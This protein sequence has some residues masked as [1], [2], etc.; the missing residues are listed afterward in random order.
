MAQSQIRG[1]GNCQ[2]NRRVG[3]REPW[4]VMPMEP[5]CMEPR[6]AAFSSRRVHD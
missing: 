5:Q 4:E 1:R 6:A 3:I 2:W